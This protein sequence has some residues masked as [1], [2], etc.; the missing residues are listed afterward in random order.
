MVGSTAGQSGGAGGRTGVCPS[1][2]FSIDRRKTCWPWGLPHLGSGT[3][4]DQNMMFKLV[5]EVAGVELFQGN[6]SRGGW[7]FPLLQ[8]SLVSGSFPGVPAFHV[9]IFHTIFILLKHFLYELIYPKFWLRNW[10][11]Y[12]LENW[13]LHER[14]GWVQKLTARRWERKGAEAGNAFSCR[15]TASCRW[16]GVGGRRAQNVPQR[17]RDAGSLVWLR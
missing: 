10:A 15:R 12:P 7:W 6:V 13:D 16:H 14:G 3:R 8:Q 17:L 5:R 9:T 4:C 1:H 11:F 2:G